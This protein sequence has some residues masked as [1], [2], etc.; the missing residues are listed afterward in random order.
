MT[1]IDADLAKSF[2]L[3]IHACLPGRFWQKT[4]LRE[5]AQS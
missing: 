5:E 3:V 4:R 1:W 2:F